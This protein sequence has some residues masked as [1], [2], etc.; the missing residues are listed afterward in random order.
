MISAILEYCDLSD[1]N[2][3]IDPLFNDC[4][5]G[6]SYRCDESYTPAYDLNKII[7]KLMEVN[8]IGD[9]EAG[10]IFNRDILNKNGMVSFILFKE[11][12][13]HRY[14]EDML[15]FSDLMPSLIGVRFKKDTHIVS[16]FDE[17]KC[18][19]ELCNQGMEEMDA[20]EH[21]DF[22]SKGAFVGPNT[23]SILIRLDDYTY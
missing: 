12:N 16:V 5:I 1:V 10:N 2:E 17:N 11:D 15:F 23:P 19:E 6:V 18:I 21:F 7:N 4:L 20:I 3:L 8:G 9:I 13:H 22:N 14:N